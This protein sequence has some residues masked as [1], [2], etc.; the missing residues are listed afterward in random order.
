MELIASRSLTSWTKTVRS[1][2]RIW[3]HFKIPD[4][5]V[6]I[7]SPGAIGEPEKDQ[8]TGACKNWFSVERW[9]DISNEKLGVTWSSSD[10]P[11]MELGGL[12]ANLPRG[13]SNP[14]AYLKTIKPSSKI[15]R[16]YEQPLA[17]QLVPTRRA[18]MVS[19][20]HPSAPWL[21]SGGCHALGVES[22][23]PLIAAPPRPRPW[24]RA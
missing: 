3:F 21:R 10:A 22:T 9:V 24:R 5:Q 11:L 19:L 23:E 1:V 14:N 13:Q 16:K 15:T 4:P 2:G 8:L 18:D 6:H 20:R 12:T 17:H 7:N